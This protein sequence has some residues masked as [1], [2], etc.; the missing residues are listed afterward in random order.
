MMPQNKGTLK[1]I[2]KEV[3]AKMSVKILVATACGGRKN[4]GRHKAIELY[5]SPRIKA[6]YNRRNDCDMA[7]LSAKY[8][9]VDSE[10][11]IESYEQILDVNRVEELL[12]Q[13]ISYI[14]NY[15]V[16]IYF[17]AG[18]RS[19]YVEL[20]NRGAIKAKK[21]VIF[22]G[23]GFMAEI[24]KIPEIISEIKNNPEKINSFVF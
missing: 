9:L 15:D 23:Y 2:P 14:K 17:K 5:R 12:P 22:L 19:L 16:V 13:V 20:M 3:G 4:P 7:I 11:I 8:G 1:Y 24:N 21:P 6:V 10:E 18:A